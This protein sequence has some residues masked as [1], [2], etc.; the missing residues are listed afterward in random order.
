MIISNA[1]AARRPHWAIRMLVV[2]TGV[3]AG[4]VTFVAQATSFKVVKDDDHG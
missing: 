4:T 3:V 2:L 1:A